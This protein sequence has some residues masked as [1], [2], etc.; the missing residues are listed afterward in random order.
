MTLR[1]AGKSAL[2]VGA[3]GLGC[4]AALVL[5]QAGIGRLALA[6]DDTVE[7][8]NLHRQILYRDDD[9]GRD[10]LDAALE[11]LRKRAQPF[12][13]IEA[14]RTRLLPENARSLVQGFDVVIE[15][16][17]NY[18]TKFLTA[19]ACRL[20]GRPVVH[21]AAVRFRATAFCVSPAGAP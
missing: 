7:L 19:D 13:T 1:L 6:D 9:V 3:G 15:G 21:G 18:A 10:K 14:V 5:V 8:S 4:P 17:D 2:V 11:A 16:A 12:Q 20:E